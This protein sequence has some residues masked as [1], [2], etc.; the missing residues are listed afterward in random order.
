MASDEPDAGEGRTT[1]AVQRYLD[2]LAAGVPAEPVVRA[3][4]SRSVERLRLLCTSLLFRS[5]RRLTLPPVNLQGEEMLSAVVERLLKAMREVRP[6]NVRQFFGLANRH[7]RWELN[8]IARR[9]A[10]R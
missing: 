6:Q 5:Y 8:D 3:L 1:I 9:L 7:M 10:A 2:E 4:L